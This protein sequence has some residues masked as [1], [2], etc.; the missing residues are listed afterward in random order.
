MI[1]L[2]L[3]Y[4]WEFGNIQKQSPKTDLNTQRRIVF[5]IVFGEI[6]MSYAYPNTWHPGN[7][8][9]EGFFWKPRE[10]TK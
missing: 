5:I 10:N 3:G 6:F 9:K 1:I 8:E 4:F 7:F 2:V